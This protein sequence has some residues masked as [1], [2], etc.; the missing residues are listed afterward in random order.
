M[1]GLISK[2]KYVYALY[3]GEG[4]AQKHTCVYK[5]TRASL[6]FLH[7]AQRMKSSIKNFFS[8][9]DQIR[10]NLRIWSHLMEKSLMENFIFCAVN[11][12]VFRVRFRLVSRLSL[13]CVGYRYDE[14]EER[15]DI[16]LPPT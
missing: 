3:M 9:C 11:L 4:V 7:T 14:D 6:G 12:E 16:I 8:N 5:G 2:K 1:E 10:R 13:L 15:E